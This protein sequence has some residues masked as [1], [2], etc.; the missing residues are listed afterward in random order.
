MAASVNI[1]LKG[2]TSL[3]KD[4]PK[5]TST[6]EKQIALAS[7][8]EIVK[9]IGKGLSG[10]FPANSL[11]QNEASTLKRK[12]K[13][14]HGDKPLFDYKKLTSSSKWR[15]E[16]STGGYLLKY[17]SLEKPQLFIYTIN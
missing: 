14:G 9:N 6:L 15:I 16:K 10:I 17:L 1:S 4:L 8:A 13:L 2:L 7:P 11:P 3:V 12:D 5:L